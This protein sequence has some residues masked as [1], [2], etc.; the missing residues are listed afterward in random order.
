MAVSGEISIEAAAGEGVVPDFAATLRARSLG[1]LQRRQV[2]TLQINLGKLCNQACLHC[3]VEAG[4][5]RTERIERATLERIEAVLDRSQGVEVVDLTGGAPELNDN[6]RWWVAR[7]R[8]RGLRVMVRCN[9]TVIFVDGQH[10]L[11]HFYRDQAVELVCSLPC[12]TA[13]NVDRQRGSGVFDQS[14]EALR[15]LNRIGFGVPGSGLRLDLVYNPLGASLPPAQAELEERYR[16]E[17]RQLFGIEF[18]RLLTITNMPIKRFAQQLRREAAHD[19]YM[20]LLVDS[21]N[22]AAAGAVMCR[23]MISVSWDGQLYD[24]DFNQML[25]LPVVGGRRTIW[26]IESFDELGGD[27]IATGSHCY[28]CTAG[29]GSSCGGEL[30]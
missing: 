23:D 1:R 2:V 7:L 19:D 8:Q 13:D 29:A 16:V 25:E 11:P 26:T 6:F 15:R 10:D 17:L 22:P 18:S 30:A 14:I 3:H 27:A 24:C 20:Q 28:G 4:P 12:Y 5:R 21:F 9:L